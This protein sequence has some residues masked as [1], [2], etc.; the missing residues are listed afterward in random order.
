MIDATSSDKIA[1]KPV[2]HDEFKNSFTNIIGIENSKLYKNRLI[3]EILNE[4]FEP[5]LK[6]MV[7]N[8]IEKY[9]K[10]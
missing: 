1:G 7:E 5:K 9:L 10:G 3:A 8:L 6:K 4:N 2:G